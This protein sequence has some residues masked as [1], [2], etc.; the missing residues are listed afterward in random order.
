MTGGCDSSRIA[1]RSLAEVV[2]GCGR[3]AP[4]RRGGCRCRRPALLCSSLQ[5]V[6]DA[7]KG[8]GCEGAM[9]DWRSLMERNGCEEIGTKEKVTQI[10]SAP[11]K[12]KLNC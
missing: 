2:E 5:L 1:I 9:E 7:V 10:R 4:R 8:M 3:Q 11:S 12:L 6:G